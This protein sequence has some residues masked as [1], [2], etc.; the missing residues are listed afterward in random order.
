MPVERCMLCGGR[1][2]G[3][4]ICTECGMDNKK[5]DRH[6][7]LNE[8]LST[9]TRQGEPGKNGAGRS[10]QPSGNY[11]QN[12]GRCSRRMEKQ[13]A[14]RQQ[15]FRKSCFSYYASD[16]DPDRGSGISGRELGGRSR[17]RGGDSAR[18]CFF[19]ER[20]APAARRP[21][22]PAPPGRYSWGSCSS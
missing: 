17:C 4:R 3:N 12:P 5:N 1:L 10:R 6:Y 2:N 20:D 11:E 13:P 21:P 8:N 18:P 9:D 15:F 7:R 19:R 22:S 16:C 14:K